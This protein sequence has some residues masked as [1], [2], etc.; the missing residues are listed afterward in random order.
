MPSSLSPAESLVS[1]H[2]RALNDLIGINWRDGSS[3][4][5]STISPTKQRQP[6]IDLV[7]QERCFLRM[8]LERQRLFKS[9]LLHTVADEIGMYSIAKKQ[10]H[11]SDL[12]PTSSGIQ[13]PSKTSITREAA[14][15]WSEALHRLRKRQKVCSAH[16]LIGISVAPCPD[17]NLLGIRFDVG[18][19]SGQF[20]SC[21]HVY[22]TVVVQAEPNLALKVLPERDSKR[23]D[24]NSGSK[25][26]LSSDSKISLQDVAYMQV[27][28]HDLPLFI[29]LQSILQR[30]LGEKEWIRIG[31][32]QDVVDND[33][34]E[35][36]TDKDWEITF[37]RCCRAIYDACYFFAMR[38]HS[39]YCL[40]SLSGCST[41]AHYYKPF[42]A[43]D[44]I[45][46]ICSIK[47]LTRSNSFDFISF[48]LHFKVPISNGEGDDKDSNNAIDH[49][50]SAIPGLAVELTFSFQKPRP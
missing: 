21:H 29:P 37:R 14:T 3:H 7:C 49:D 38:E 32:V 35:E 40:E 45:R 18:I 6:R 23:G 26:S 27:L 10:S 13:H 8:E 28:Q 16:R 33:N 31:P 2:S 5:T 19:D 41:A 17:P 20:V 30:E 39:F 42:Q 25:R 47:N 44:G 1:I 22:W 43:P 12:Y 36:T 48:H 50:F 34:D 11:T 24:S 4:G 46:E 9:L 15:V